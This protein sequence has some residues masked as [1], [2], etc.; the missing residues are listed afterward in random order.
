MGGGVLLFLPKHLLQQPMWPD[1]EPVCLSES[2]CLCVYLR[3]HVRL[4]VSVCLSI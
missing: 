2:A 1:G 4:S 3:V